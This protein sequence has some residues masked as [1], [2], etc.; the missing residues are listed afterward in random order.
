M[1]KRD[2]TSKAAQNVAEFKKEKNTFE[3]SYLDK[4]NE[5][6][7]P[8]SIDNNKQIPTDEE[9]K[10]A[11]IEAGD[12]RKTYYLSLLHVEAI[13]MLSYKDRKNISET[14]CELL[15]EAIPPEI[16]NDARESLNRLSIEELR[17]LQGKK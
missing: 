16:M 6:Q 17:K 2:Y 11:L 4:E 10:I 12:T 1:A 9:V 15:N 8:A 3:T 13:R 5:E 14:V 7:A